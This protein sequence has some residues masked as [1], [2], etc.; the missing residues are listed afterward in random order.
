MREAVSQL[1][2]VVTD[3]V[4]MSENEIQRIKTGKAPA[5]AMRDC[6]DQWEATIREA[7]QVLARFNPD[8]PQAG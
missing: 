8:G 1:I 6:I 4:L 3:F 7:R 5:P 2:E